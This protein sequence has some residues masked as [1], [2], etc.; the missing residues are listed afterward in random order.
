MTYVALSA[1][2]TGSV[3]AGVLDMAFMTNLLLQFETL[4]LEELEAVRKAIVDAEL[5]MRQCVDALASW[6]NRLKLSI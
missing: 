5:P 2:E 4:D 6:I 1:I 3:D